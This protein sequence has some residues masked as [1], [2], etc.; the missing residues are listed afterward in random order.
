MSIALTSPQHRA[1]VG[2]TVV[3]MIVVVAFIVILAGIGAPLVSRHISHARVN[4]AAHVLVGGL[5]QALSLAGRQRRP[6]R[7]TV[8]AAQRTLV[9]ADRGTGQSIARHAFGPASDYKVETLS[10]VPTSVDILPH[11]VVTAA[12]TLTVGIGGYSRQVT[13]TRG[14]QVRLQP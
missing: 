9:I 7:V 12:A 13:L 14:G 5:E 6:V 8:N 4:G 10:S 2:F 3:E 1:R 11:G